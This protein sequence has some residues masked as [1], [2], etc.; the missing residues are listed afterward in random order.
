MPSVMPIDEVRAGSTDPDEL[1]PLLKRLV[2][3]PFLCFRASYGDELTLH[4]GEPVVYESPRMKGRWKGS[5]ILAARASSWILEPGTPPGRLFT[6]DNIVVP[7]RSPHARTLELAEIEASPTIEPHSLV[8]AAVLAPAPGGILLSVTFSDGS[9]L[10]ILPDRA[11]NPNGGDEEPISD[12]E[13]F[14][15]RHRV[16]KVGPGISWAYLDSQVKP[17]EEGR[18]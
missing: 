17:S 13:I 9:N 14:M 8:T 11:T 2:G 4:L 10:V 3:K 7:D 18:P 15:P 16:L 5:Y 6:S 12:W 1:R